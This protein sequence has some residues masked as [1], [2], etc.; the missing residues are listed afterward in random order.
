MLV[1]GRLAT[2]AGDVRIESTGG[3]ESHAINTN[4]GNVSLIAH[5]PVTVQGAINGNDVTVDASTDVAFGDGARVNAARTIAVTAGSGVTFAGAATLDVQAT[6]AINV[7]AK[8]GD[9]TAAETVRINSRG[10][11]VSLLAPNGRVNVPASVLVAAPVTTPVVP[12]ATIISAVNTLPAL[13][14]QYNP[15]NQFTTPNNVVT[16]LL[17]GTT[18]KE[19]TKEATDD[20]QN[21]IKKT[22]CN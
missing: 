20:A 9:L 15:L 13:S 14:A 2:G 10:A 1:L 16:P 7:L 4:S 5:S 3:I 8:N 11:P 18:S 22:Y 21:G 19:S 6:G 12:P 17:A